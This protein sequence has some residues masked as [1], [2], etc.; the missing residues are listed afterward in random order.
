MR[1]AARSNH[2]ILEAFDREMWCPVLQAR[3]E[4]NDLDALRA[5]LGETAKEDPDLAGCYSLDE[6][7][8]AAIAAR[9]GVELDTAQLRAGE[10]D[11]RLF[12][13]KRSF[14]AP[15]LIHTGY[16]LPLLLEGRKKL[17]R[18][19]DAYPPATFDGEDRFD[20]WVA[21]GVLHREEVIEPFDPPAKKYLGHRT[22]FYTPKGEEWRI[23]ASKLIWEASGKSGGWNEHFERLEGMLFGYEDWQNDWWINIGLHG[24]GFGGVR[25][26]CA[27]TAGGLAWMEAAGFRAL[28]PIDRPSL[29]VEIYDVTA[30]AELDTF[31]REDPDSVALVRF[32]ILGKDATPFMN[33]FRQ[34]GP[35]HV[36]RDRIPDLNANLR[37]PVV[38]VARRDPSSSDSHAKR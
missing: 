38:I 37:G 20:H 24:G 16:E 12:R 10:L 7:D 4:V 34:P 3:F 25:F 5:L 28:P 14:E 6:E 19:S 31:M 8:L 29:P 17:A 2:F 33:D 9:F 13:W 36:Q 26:C 35:W 11:I 27:V 1:T 21:K 32:N 15:Y 23:P 22:V 18:M 30:E